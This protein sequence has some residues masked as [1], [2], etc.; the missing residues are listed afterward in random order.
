MAPN[1]PSATILT[2]S[3]HIGSHNTIHPSEDRLLSPLECQILQTI[4]LS[5]KWGDAIKKYGQSNVRAMIGE[6]IP[7][8]FTKLHGK[9]L[10]TLLEK[11]STKA[12]LP[13]DNVGVSK[14]WSKLSS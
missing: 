8:T 12:L 10:L 7:P 4:P 3:G 11:H 14:A 5:F 1:K 9:A 6:A 13:A 2:A